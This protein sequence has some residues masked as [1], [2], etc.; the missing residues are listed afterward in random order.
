MFTKKDKEAIE[1]RG[2]NVSAIEEQLAH[3]QEGFPPLDIVEP[4]VPGNGI[5]QLDQAEQNRYAARYEGWKGTRVK[6]VPASGAASRMFSHLFQAQEEL[7]TGGEKALN[8]N[9]LLFFERLKEFAFYPLLEKQPL[10]LN[11]KQQVLRSLLTDKGL[12]YAQLPKGL[13]PFHKY[14]EGPKTPFEEH[15]TEAAL[16]TANPDGTAAVHFT[17]SEEHEP[18]F[19]ALWEQIQE[20]VTLRFGLTFA[21]SFSNQSPSTD[22]LAVQMNNTPFRNDDGSLLFR[23]GGHGALLKNLHTLKEDLIVIRNIDNVVPE[24][25]LEPV[26]FWR[27]V[28]AGFL[29]DCQHQAH[30]YIR[31]LKKNKADKDLVHEV[32]DFLK[33]TFCITRLPLNYDNIPE[34]ASALIAVLD[35][36]IRV[37]GMVPVSGEPGGG[38]FKVRE[39]DGSISLQILEEVQLG[40]KKYPSTHFNP[41]DIVCSIKDAMGN[42]YDLQK[43]ADP[44]TG[45]ISHK[46]MEGRELRALEWPGLWNGAMSRWNTVFVEVPLST[47]NP[48]KTAIDLLRKEHNN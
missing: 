36:P 34:C 32:V 38:P 12:G 27:K 28:L 10:D 41:V 35:R 2:L 4:A 11:D 24:T 16:A 40:G 44:K 19:K 17:V 48:V 33:N 47:F 18:L 43:F 31:I 21:V 42:L 14:A 7:Q 3:F 30:D 45:F 5:T 9:A 46:T 26:L 20:A 8:A 6:F 1:S 23:P 29:L 22:T 15:L 39:E 37:C 13:I 25:R